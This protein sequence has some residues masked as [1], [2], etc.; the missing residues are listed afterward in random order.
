MKIYLASD[1][2]G[3]NLKEKIKLWLPEWGHEAE[4][5]GPYEFDPMDDYPDFISKAAAKVS[6]DP[7]NNK[8]IILGGTGQGEA[9]VA[10]KFPGVR[11]VVYYGGLEEIVILSKEH[12]NAN[13]LSMGASFLD[14]FSARAMIKLWLD[15]GF[16]SE[17]RHERRINKIK[18]IEEKI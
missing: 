14:E 11:A 3:F 8:A 4:D 2:R 17:E 6:E 5:M 7:E 12:N 18:E 15:T 10:N 9:I 16:H 1:H 13:I